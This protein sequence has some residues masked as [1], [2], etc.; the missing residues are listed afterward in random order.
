MGTFNSCIL[1][2]Q[3]A[4][5]KETLWRQEKSYP[6]IHK[7]FWKSHHKMLLLLST[8]SCILSK[9]YKCRQVWVDFH[10]DQQK[11][12]PWKGLPLPQPLPTE[13]HVHVPVLQKD[14]SSQ[15]KVSPTFFLITGRTTFSTLI[16]GNGRTIL[17]ENT[18]K[19]K[20]KTKNSQ[21]CAVT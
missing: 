17:P 11:R 3:R 21:T 8:L 14:T 15:R 16:P 7:I 6:N 1:H 20:T 4:E 19:P 5:L 9:T 12:L 13:L 18:K 10:W 2:P